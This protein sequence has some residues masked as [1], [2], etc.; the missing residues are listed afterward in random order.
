MKRLVL[1][2]DSTADLPA[3][4][5]AERGIRVTA[6]TFAF[7]GR[8]YTDGEVPLEEL[9]RA[10][11]E[12]AEAPAPFGAPE[13]AFRRVFR[14]IMDDGGEPVCVV[15]PYDV[16]PSFTTAIAAML[17][18]DG[19]DMKVVNPGVSSAGLCSLLVSLAGGLRGGWSR[20]ELLDA[21]DELGPH[22]DALFLPAET[23][24]LA[25]SGRLNA[26]EQK[27]GELDGRLPI[28]RA[29]NRLNGVALVEDFAAGLMGLV[30]LSGGRSGGGPVVVTIDHADAPAAA[31]EVAAAME[32]RWDVA[33]L[34]VTGLSATLGAQLGPGTVGVG[35]APA[36]EEGGRDA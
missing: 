6:T 29:G 9:Y 32:A 7:Q 15:A 4:V 20:T 28:V 33:R 36:Y 27:L 23:R 24:W 1:V 19:A 18:L 30:E 10:M 35:V 25:A 34:I 22:C 3:G 5:A 16:N 31:R 2:T 12:G 8:T 21:V 17:S 13:V 26:I 14:E 11:R